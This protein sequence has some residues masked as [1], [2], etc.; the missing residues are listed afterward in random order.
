MY[1]GGTFDNVINLNFFVSGMILCFFKY[2]VP[3]SWFST[4]DNCV[5][6]R[7]KKYLF[8][9]H[10]QEKDQV[11]LKKFKILVHTTETQMHFSS[12]YT[13]HNTFT[14]NLRTFFLTD[15][16]CIVSTSILDPDS[17]IPYTDPAF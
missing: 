2:L 13:V 6:I 16:E 10:L 14:M 3:K 7:V 9:L 8:D 11:L 15:S 1:S 17:L 12:K 4:Q 5:L